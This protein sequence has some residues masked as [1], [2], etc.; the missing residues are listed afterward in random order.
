MEFV[1]AIGELK[2]LPEGTHLLCPR[3]NEDDYGRYDDLGQVNE[4]GKKVKDLV[5][6]AKARKE[7]FLSS[8]RILA[9][10]AD[11]VEELQTWVLSR[12]DDSL[13][14]CDLCIKE[15]YTGKIWLMELLKE[16]YQEEDI[17]AFAQRVDEWDIKRITRN[18]TNAT[19]Q[20]KSV[21]PQQI[22]LDTLDRASLLAIFETL[23][24]EAMLRSD[25]LLQEYFDEPFKLIQ[26]K[27]TLKIS[28]YV[29]A[30]TRFLFDSNQL[31]SFWAIS[32][33][34]R[35]NRPPTTLE[36][37]WALRDGILSA[38]QAASQQP[39]TDA[40]H[41]ASVA[42][43]AANSEKTGQGADHASASGLGH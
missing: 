38:L 31:R 24:C 29:P 25:S 2:A 3:Q 5:V 8:M 26:T 37:E 27:R 15:Y 33:W 7:K 14:K 41:S 28:D 36:F 9:Y 11:G 40:T 1:D 6:E 12:L 21:P 22:A 17:E 35:Y 43:N 39:P 34:T 32:T 42:W 16:N 13:E 18:L 19:T 4:D 20:L 30:V 10:N 23:S